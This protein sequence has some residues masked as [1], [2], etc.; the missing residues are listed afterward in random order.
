MGT[1]WSR[2]W[3]GAIGAIGAIAAGVWALSVAPA[4]AEPVSRDR[5]L[6]A[7]P[8]LDAMAGKAIADHAVPGLAIAVVHQ[9][10][11]V[12]LKGFGL[13]EAG[14][15]ETVDPDTVFQ[16]A[17]LSKPVSSSVIAALVSAGILGWD[18]R[19]A[20]LD[21][22]F[23]LRDAYP[24]AELT[25]RDLLAHRS[26]LPGDAGNELEDIGF[27]RDT[28]LHRLRLVPP[29]SSFRAGYSYSNAGF[30]EGGV[31]AARPTGKPWEQVAEERLYRPLGMN[32]T[33]SRYAD[34]VA[35]AN[36]AALHIDLGKGWEA[37]LRREPDMQAPAGGVSSS[38]RDLAQWMRLELGG[39]L[40]DGERL[41][42]A[43]A[44]A[45]T[46]QPLMARGNNPVTGAASF[47]GLG[48]NVEFGR[49]GLN[50]GHAGAFSVGA[51]TLV[52]LYPDASLGILVLAN[53]FPTGAPEGLADS[54]FDWVFD[55]AVSQDWM[56][57]WDDAYAGLLGPATAAAKA[58]YAAPPATASPALPN[59]AYAG[60]YRNAYVGDAVVAEEGGSLTLVVG[61]EGVRRYPLRHF[62]RDTFL[63]FPNAETP[64]MPAAVRFAIRPDGRAEAVTIEF[65]DEVGLGRLARVT[66]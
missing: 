52:S 22:A 2:T 9:G 12:Y 47:Y 30:T 33:S 64:D 63:A 1:S 44:L 32:A 50:W 8:K 20:D 57:A 61:P 21:P 17:S 35:R 3:Q 4:G 26:G 29:S 66:N 55:G 6:A 15:P 10:E 39:G 25:V 65:L 49:H 60:R 46:H 7:L 34:F 54:F 28:V 42:S 37:K 59:P 62:D 45:A 36:R 13:R 40:F 14:K 53:A 24:T 51:R 58:R 31:A 41:I 43:D 5:V 23:R 27:D 11:V 19:I 16:I 56:T 48:W 38:A 18:S